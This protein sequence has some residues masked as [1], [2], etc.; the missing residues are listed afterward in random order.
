MQ[1]QWYIF[2]IF[3]FADP[4]TSDHFYF[5]KQ[6]TQNSSVDCPNNKTLCC[7]CFLWYRNY[8]KIQTKLHFKKTAIWKENLM[9]CKLAFVWENCRELFRLQLWHFLFLSFFLFVIYTC[10][11]IY[12]YVY[13]YIYIYIY[14]YM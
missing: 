8:R 4:E 1:R 13:I 12:M 3:G 5:A 11:Y 7:L 9:W 10:M 2:F 14:I 6:P